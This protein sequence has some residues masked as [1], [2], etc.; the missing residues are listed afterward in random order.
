MIALEI[1]S[2]GSIQMLHSDDVDLREFG[3]IEVTRASHVE[4]SNEHGEW[5]VTS[6]KTG[7]ILNAFDTRKEALEW[8]SKYYSPSGKGWAELTGG[9]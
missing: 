7:L 4:F 3:P 1:T 5:L 6:A 9:N 8:E 2:E